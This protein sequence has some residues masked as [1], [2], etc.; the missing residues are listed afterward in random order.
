MEKWK[1]MDR[2][3]GENEIMKRYVRVFRELNEMKGI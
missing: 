3:I 2:G 1:K